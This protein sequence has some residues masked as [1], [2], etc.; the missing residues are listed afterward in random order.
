MSKPSSVPPLLWPAMMAILVGVIAAGW[1][2]ATVPENTVGNALPTA[3]VIAPSAI[4][5]SSAATSLQPP[6]GPTV[7]ATASSPEAPI[8]ATEPTSPGLQPSKSPS[9]VVT[10]KENVTNPTPE[11]LAAIPPPPEAAAAMKAGPPPDVLRGMQN[12]PMHMLQGIN[13]PPPEFKHAL[14]PGGRR[15]P[16]SK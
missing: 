5:A 6:G 14:N 13:N 10:I 12:P 9:P 4:Q 8:T 15:P 7:A 16:P 1:Y 2:W 11:E 3:D